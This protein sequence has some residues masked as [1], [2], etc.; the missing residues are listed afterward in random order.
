[1]INAELT[2]DPSSQ[3]EDQPLDGSLRPKRLSEYVGQASLTRNLRIILAS[4][5][6]RQSS[7]DHL[8]FYGPPGLGKTTLAS[9]VAHEAGVNFKPTAGPSLSKVS[10]LASILTGLSEGD[11]LF[12]DE[13]HRLPA[14]VEEILYTAMEDFCLDIVIGQGPAA[15]SVRI[16]LPK[17]CLVGAT[18][19]LS[20]LSAPLRDRFGAVFQLEYYQPEEIAQILIRSAAL[21][22]IEIKPGAVQLL[23]SRS[24]RTPRLANRLLRRVRDFAIVEGDGVIVEPIVESAMQLLAIDSQGLDR[25]DRQFLEVIINFYQG[26]PVGIETLA[27]SVGEERETL[28]S[29][30]EPYLMQL[31]LVERTAKGRKITAHG[32]AHLN[33]VGALK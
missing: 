22:D 18:T 19:R 8:L 3:A 21:L 7:I 23:A 4:A 17:F 31:G 10:D 2:L 28:E 24:R 30:V 11:V 14:A 9:I 29:V 33:Q 32:M 13:I 20:L 16:E 15:K 26:G 6:Q 27:A 5:K 1:M 25:L 12:I